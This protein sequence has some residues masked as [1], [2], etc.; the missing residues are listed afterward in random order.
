MYTIL[1]LFGIFFLDCVKVDQFVLFPILFTMFTIYFLEKSRTMSSVIFVSSFKSIAIAKCIDSLALF[2]SIHPVSFISE[3]VKF[4]ALSFQILE[5]SA[6][7]LVKCQR[8]LKKGKEGKLTVRRFLCRYK[9]PCLVFCL[10]AIVLYKCLHFRKY[11]FL[12]H[13]SNRSHIGHHIWLQ[14]PKRINH[15]LSK[16]Y[17]IAL[18]G[19]TEAKVD[20]SVLN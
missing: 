4:A 8:Q 18:S 7:R 13:A 5:I 12:G 3:I 15:H 19:F 16:V 1:F 2:Q 14:S 11:T 17:F 9:H 10:H 20:L 6:L